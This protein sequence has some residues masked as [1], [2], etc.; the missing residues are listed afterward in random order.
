MRPL[1]ALAY[2]GGSA[3]Y[4]SC[5]C[6]P[7]GGVLGYLK[8]SVVLWD[9]MMIRFELFFFF[10]QAEDGIR[11]YKVIG[12]QTCALPISAEPAM[13]DVRH[14]AALG[15][16]AQDVARLPLGA[17]EQQRSTVGG[18]LAREPERLLVHRQGALEI[19]EDRKSVGRERV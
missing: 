18:Q 8:V 10:L 4:S 13:V 12:V 5:C 1:L 17:D 6:T 19:D 11:D 2:C 15:L 3:V 14:R 16:L 9:Y 7:G